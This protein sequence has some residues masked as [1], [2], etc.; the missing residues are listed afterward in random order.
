MKRIEK[1]KKKMEKERKK[2]RKKEIEKEIRFRVVT[3]RLFWPFYWRQV[4][5]LI[6][7]SR[8]QGRNKCNPFQFQEKNIPKWQLF[9]S[10]HKTLYNRCNRSTGDPIHFL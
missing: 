2:E 1:G 6:A 7:I 9:I 8:R 10:N 4:W 3:G 5:F